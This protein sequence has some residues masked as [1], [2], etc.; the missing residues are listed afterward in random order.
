MNNNGGGTIDIDKLLEE[1]GKI[2][3]D[4]ETTHKLAMDLWNLTVDNSL[5]S[6]NAVI[7]R[8]YAEALA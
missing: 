3:G 7:Y 5:A 6:V 8:R 2:H 1:R 4:A